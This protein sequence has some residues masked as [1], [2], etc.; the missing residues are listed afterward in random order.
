MM[1]HVM[2]NDTRIDR[3]GMLVLASTG[4]FKQFH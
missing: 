3:H 1:L 2:H 4:F